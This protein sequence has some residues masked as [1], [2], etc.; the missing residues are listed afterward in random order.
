[1]WKFIKNTYLKYFA[2]SESGFALFLFLLFCIG[3]YYIGKYLLPLFIA[4]F[5][6]FLLNEAV[7]WLHNTFKLRRVIA[8]S[9]VFFLFFG[10]SFTASFVMLPVLW[11]RLRQLVNAVP[12]MIQ[13]A[14]RWLHLL[15][16]RY[17]F[18]QERDVDNFI[19]ITE[20]N[21]NA[22]GQRILSSSLASLGD[23]L[24][25]VVYSSLVMIMVFFLLKDYNK[26]LEYFSKFLPKEHKMVEDLGGRMK[27][28]MLKYIRGKLLEMLI[29]AIVSWIVFAVM[30]LNFSF[31]LALGT[32]VSVIIPYVGAFVAGFPVGIVAFS[33]FGFEQYFFYIILAYTI[34]QILDGNVLVPYLFSEISNINPVTI[35]VAILVFGNI[36][37]LWG[38]LFAIP[39]A[40]F[41]KTLVEYW[42]RQSA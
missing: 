22:Y 18:I 20:K 29:V 21:I 3:F 6:S 26:W 7:V 5:L 40:T 42:P 10:A 11:E 30:G 2:A 31:L 38:V 4:L 41:I 1:M 27:V 37:G 15:P 25:A 14:T 32:G 9:L 8:V 39:L 12:G 34:I 33:Q 17:E 28:E 19:N 36:W 16:E 23:L 35:I 24:T 13:D